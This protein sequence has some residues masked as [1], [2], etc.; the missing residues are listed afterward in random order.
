MDQLIFFALE[1]G[2]Y[3]REFV[4]GFVFILLGF[5]FYLIYF[6]KRYILSSSFETI[7]SVLDDFSLLLLIAKIL[8]GFGFFIMLI[9]SHHLLNN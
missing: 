6:F 2:I 8:S 9:S 7:E 5:V 3:S 1:K 4:V